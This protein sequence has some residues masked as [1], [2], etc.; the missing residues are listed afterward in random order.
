[1]NRFRLVK[2]GE[3]CLLRRNCSIVS[4]TGRLDLGRGVPCP[5]SSGEPYQ[6]GGCSGA[7]KQGWD[8]VHSALCRA[9]ATFLEVKD[10]GTL[11]RV[12]VSTRWFLISA[13][14]WLSSRARRLWRLL[15][16]GDL[17]GPLKSRLS[18]LPVPA[19]CCSSQDDR[20]CLQRPSGEESAR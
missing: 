12:L 6:S 1:M 13:A 10:L 3:F 19:L 7:E 14:F 15:L 17:R 11:A 9:G 2:L 18:C 4:S 8:L 16:P 20:G 5:T